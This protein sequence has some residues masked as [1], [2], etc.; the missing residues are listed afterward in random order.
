MLSLAITLFWF[1]NK[2]DFVID[3]PCTSTENP[4]HPSG[5]TV[6]PDRSLVCEQTIR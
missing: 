2:P 3:N 6:V 1:C 4:L 5:K